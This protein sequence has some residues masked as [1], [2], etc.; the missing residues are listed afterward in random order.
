MGHAPQ[1]TTEADRRPK[2]FTVQRMMGNIGKT[3]AAR[4]TLL[5]LLCILNAVIA[6]KAE[7]SVKSQLQR[8]GFSWSASIDRPTGIATSSETSQVWNGSDLECK[9]LRAKPKRRLQCLQN[10]FESYPNWLAKKLVTF[11]VLRA[12]ENEKGSIAIQDVFFGCNLLT[13]DRPTSRF[14][15]KDRERRF[16]VNLPVTGG[17]MAYREDSR[18]DRHGDLGRLLFSVVETTTPNKTTRFS[19]ETGI[20]GYRP[21]IAGGPPVSRVR[22]WMYQSTQS[23][24][25]AYVM[26]R[27]H[28]S[29]CRFKE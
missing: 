5:F 28:R 29:C 16:T 8:K 1:L 2:R 27:F 10:N 12:I 21:A 6:S 15:V 9:L 18:K 17:I 13:F 26:W 20:S 23:Y 24:V 7:I 3:P 22:K 4:S 25:H 14:Q 11:G 19:L